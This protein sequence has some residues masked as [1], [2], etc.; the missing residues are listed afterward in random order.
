MFPTLDVGG[1]L[2]LK[3]TFAGTLIANIVVPTGATLQFEQDAALRFDK[4][5]SGTGV[6]NF[7]GPGRTT[8]GG[9]SNGFTGTVNVNAG[10]FR[11]DDPALAVT[12]A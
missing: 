7:N 12:W 8:F 4:A 11:I 9:S 2:K 1:T 6:I 5:V 10:E 3:S